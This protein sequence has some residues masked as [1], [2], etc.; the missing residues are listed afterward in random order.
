MP[1][2]LVSLERLVCP[3]SKCIMEQ[4]CDLLWQVD[5]YSDAGEQ[6]AALSSEFQTAISSRNVFHPDGHALAAS[7]SSG[8]VLI[9]R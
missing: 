7:T 9:Y 6:I 2:L 3:S 1:I 8:R 4:S 5:M